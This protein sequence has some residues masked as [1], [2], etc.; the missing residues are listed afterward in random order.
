MNG[1]AGFGPGTHNAPLFP[2][3]EIS[4]PRLGKQKVSDWL[5]MGN[6]GLLMVVC[7]NV[8]ITGEFSIFGVTFEA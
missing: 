4:L 1:I 5:G 3:R 2:A 8:S 7:S 6:N